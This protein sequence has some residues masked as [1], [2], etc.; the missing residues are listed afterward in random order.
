MLKFLQ[1]Q[2]RSIVENSFVHGMRGMDELFIGLLVC[3]GN[4]GCTGE[5][6]RNDLICGR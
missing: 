2:P 3:Q 1:C 5:T 6:F 4:Y